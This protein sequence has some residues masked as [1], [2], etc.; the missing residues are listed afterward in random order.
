MTVEVGEGSMGKAQ[1]QAE[2][3]EELPCMGVAVP[4]GCSEPTVAA[5]KRFRRICVFCASSR[6]KKDIFSDVAF[7]LGRELVSG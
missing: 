5:S 6:G 2:E 3:E 1:G 7:S 4:A